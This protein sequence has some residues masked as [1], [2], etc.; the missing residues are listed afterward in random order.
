MVVNVLLAGG[1][2]YVYIN[3]RSHAEPAKAGAHGAAKHGE[4]AEGEDE[5]EEE[6]AEAKEHEAAEDEADDK[7]VKHSK[8]GPLIEIGSFIANLSGPNGAQSRYAK[9]SLHAE[10][11]NEEAKLRIETAVVPL[12]AEALM[13]LSNLKA[14]DVIGQEKIVHLSEE[15][16]KRSNKL[17]GKKSI[18]RM[19]FSELVVQ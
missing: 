5:G 4:D 15:L 19:Y 10:A 6:G 9:V 7:K 2:A 8:F 1:L 13:V 14:E 16:L 3:G 17:L 18:K 11:L 12:K